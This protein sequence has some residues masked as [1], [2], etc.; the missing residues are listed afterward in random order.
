MLGPAAELQVGEGVA[1]PEI[2]KLSNPEGATPLIDPVTVAVNVT[3]P[4]KVG[5]GDEEM[6][7]VGTPEVIVVAVEEVTAA[8]G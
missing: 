8:T 6:I 5:L 2:A 4:P 7:T 1:V 3:D